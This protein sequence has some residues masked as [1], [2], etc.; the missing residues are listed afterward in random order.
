MALWQ[1]LLT[2]PGP[3]VAVDVVP[4][5]APPIEAGFALGPNEPEQLAGVA[6]VNGLFGVTE[7]ELLRAVA[8]YRSLA[9]CAVMSPGGE[10]FRPDADVAPVPPPAPEA[11][12]VE[13]WGARL[14]DGRTMLVEVACVGVSAGGARVWHC[15]TPGAPRMGRVS[16]SL[17]VQVVALAEGMELAAILSPAELAAEDAARPVV[18]DGAAGD[19]L[20]ALNRALGQG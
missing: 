15:P 7:L 5:S 10:E 8:R 13:T 3:C 12:A 17:V 9:V 16:P 18:V 2:G 11:P 14:R 6:A 20:R 1:L 19:A 4:W